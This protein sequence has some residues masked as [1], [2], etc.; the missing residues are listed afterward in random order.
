MKNNNN[1]NIQYST[2]I[3]TVASQWKVQ[4]VFGELTMFKSNYY[5]N[6]FWFG[7]TKPNF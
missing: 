6:F 1:T 4:F 2:S 5:E 3:E 7:L